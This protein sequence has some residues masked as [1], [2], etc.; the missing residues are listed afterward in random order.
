MGPTVGPRARVRSA[1]MVSWPIGLK[2][3]MTNYP[4]GDMATD[5]LGQPPIPRGHFWKKGKEHFIS[6]QPIGLF[7]PRSDN[8]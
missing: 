4:H 3:G 2:I 6:K 1:G 5:V 7:V 8:F